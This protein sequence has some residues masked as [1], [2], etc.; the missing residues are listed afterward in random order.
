MEN[1]EGGVFTI[2]EKKGKEEKRSNA[3]TG[4]LKQ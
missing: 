1:R 2:W 3:V 4:G